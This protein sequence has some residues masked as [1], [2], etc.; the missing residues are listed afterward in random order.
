[1]TPAATFERLSA[2]ER[3]A[4]L[5]ARSLAAQGAEHL[6]AEAELESELNG[7]ELAESLA[8]VIAE[9]GEASGTFTLWGR[10]PATCS[11]YLIDA[12][13]REYDHGALYPSIQAEIGLSHQK[14][15][16]WGD[17]FLAFLDGLGLWRFWSDD[18]AKYRLESILLHCGLP[19]DAWDQ[20]WRSWL[21]PYLDLRSAWDSVEELIELALSDSHA[22]PTLR[23]TTKHILI[24]RGEMIQRL[25]SNAVEAG[26]DVRASGFVDTARD[27]GLPPAALESL[28]RVLDAP[29]LRWPELVFDPAG[30][31]TVFL[32]SPEQR[33]P[34]APFRRRVDVV[35][36]VYSSTEEGRRLAHDDA[37]ATRRG[38]FLVIEPSRMALPPSPG[39]EAIVRF[40]G[41]GRLDD[42]Q[43]RRM[44][45]RS[46]AGIVLA[47]SKD[48]NGRFI[49]APLGARLRPS[50]EAC[51]LVPSEYRIE[52]SGSARVTHVTQLPGEWGGWTAYEAAAPEGGSVSLLDSEGNCLAEWSI[53]QTCSVTLES[54][55]SLAIGSLIAGTFPPRVFGRLMPRV[56]I[57]SVDPTEPLNASQWSCRVEW[58]HMGVPNS[59]EVPVQSDDRGFSLVADPNSVTDALPEVLAD[60]LLRCDGPPRAGRLSRTFARVPMTRPRATAIVGDALSSLMVDYSVESSV[61]LPSAR[62]YG[63]DSGVSVGADAAKRGYVISAPLS[64]NHVVVRVPGDNADVVVN[65]NLLGV[66]VTCDGTDQDLLTT[67]RIP[68]ALLSRMAGGY[69]RLHTHSGSGA[70]VRLVCRQAGAAESV[71][72]C[73]G[74]DGR[75]TETLGLVELAAAIPGATNTHL[76]VDILTDGLSHSQTLFEVTPGLGLGDISVS[77]ESAGLNFDSQHPALISMAAGFRD[78]TAPW[79][80]TAECILEVGETRARF[81][82]DPFPL[83]MGK[84]GL[85]VSPVD[86]WADGPQIDFDE[87]PQLVRIVGPD[88]PHDNEPPSGPYFSDLRKLLLAA[89]GIGTRPAMKAPGRPPSLGMLEADAEAS[90]E[91]VRNALRDGRARAAVL[92]AD[93]MHLGNYRYAQSPPVLRALLGR[94]A[95]RS[96]GQGIL[97]RATSLRLPVLQVRKSVASSFELDELELAWTVD[98]FVGY[99]A[100]WMHCLCGAPTQAHQPAEAWLERM[101]LSAARSKELRVELRPNHGAVRSAANDPATV[102]ETNLECTIT[103]QGFVKW[104]GQA[105]TRQRLEASK[106]IRQRLPEAR[107]GLQSFTSRPG[108]LKLLAHELRTRDFGEG[109]KTV[110]NLQFITGCIA[111]ACMATALDDPDGPVFCAELAGA[112]PSDRA[113]TAFTELMLEAIDYCYEP[114]SLDAALFR[115][116]YQQMA[117]GEL[118]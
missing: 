107:R 93:I 17:R 39:Y 22:A 63:R 7:I 14:V 113:F 34:A 56:R 16:Q 61:S 36:D 79:R 47:F 112:T 115:M 106:W 58:K 72:R 10:F 19:D 44:R 15:M 26:R 18:V 75:Y 46:V 71:L 25:I 51:Y 3:E 52:T 5:A 57:T 85:W 83:L 114:M 108:P 82:P 59:V 28:E 95:V 98:P 67:H 117:T 104:I 99:L 105:T 53:G 37:P 21:L 41:I 20:M 86:A 33:I 96:G 87:E 116:A 97:A 2:F 24:N 84:Y 110:A 54:E 111:V 92:G 69:V 23:T 32:A 50:S 94:T 29:R 48:R 103:T 80:T 65:L 60:G 68:M 13:R 4:Y 1:M 38:G 76:D 102:G 101:G 45:W 8:L 43:E 55:D 12:G 100:S 73:V 9:E 40:S 49:C 78:L 6:L 62:W 64:K 91:A 30:A 66:E 118:I 109:V 89:E 88:E 42:T 74:R 81:E 90:V 27:Y 31:V 70:E 77:N 11:F 35:F